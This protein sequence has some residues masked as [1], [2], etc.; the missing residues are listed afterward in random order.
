MSAC[1]TKTLPCA[2]FIAAVVITM[3]SFGFGC[4]MLATGGVG[5]SMAPF[6][7]S[8]ITGSVAFWATPPNVKNDSTSEVASAVEQT[9]ENIKDNNINKVI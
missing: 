5:A 3:A 8:L 4:G 2:K 7:A 1:T 9:I 6:Y